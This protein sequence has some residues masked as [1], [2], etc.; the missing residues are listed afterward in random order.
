MENRKEVSGGL[1]PAPPGGCTV[2]SARTA[3]PVE[4]SSGGGWFSAQQPGAQPM[5][6]QRRTLCSVAAL[7]SSNS[8]A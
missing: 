5:G 8:R 4:G 6:R 3:V 1:V 7:A 2:N